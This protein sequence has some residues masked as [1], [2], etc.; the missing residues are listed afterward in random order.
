[1]TQELY[2]TV[3]SVDTR[4]LGEPTV[5]FAAAG[6]TTLYVDDA[7]SFN[8][9][10][11]QALVDGVLY[12]Y[13]EI[14]VEVNTLELLTVLEADVPEGALVEVVPA[15]PVKVASVDLGGEGDAVPVIVPH[16]LV[17][18]LVDGVRDEH[19]SETVLCDLKGAQLVIVDVVGQ[20]LTKGTID[21]DRLN[22]G[23]VADLV[24]DPQ[25]LSERWSPSEPWV[26]LGPDD[27]YPE[28]NYARCTNDGATID[29]DF[30]LTDMIPVQAG[31]SVRVA[32]LLRFNSAAVTGAGLP[33]ESR[34]RVRVEFY[35]ADGVTSLS[36]SEQLEE[37]LSS[38][39][40]PDVWTTLAASFP[41]PEG[42][43]F[44]RAKFQTSYQTG[45]AVDFIK[46]SVQ[47]P[48]NR[49]ASSSYVEGAS[50]WALDDNVS[51]VEDLNVLNELGAGG[52]TTGALTVGGVD[53]AT[54]INTMPRGIVAYD[55]STTG[56]DTGNNYSL[57]EFAMGPSE[58]GRLYRV[59]FIGHL[60]SA[61]IN[62]VYD[63]H[64]HMTTNNTTPTSA[65]PIIRS[66][67]V[68][69]GPGAAS[70]AFIV[71]KVFATGD[72][73]NVRFLLAM[74]RQ[75]GN[76]PGFVYNGGGRQLTAYVED[77][78]LYASAADA[79]TLSQKSFYT[80]PATPQ[81]PNPQPK[82]PQPDP[83]VTYTDVPFPCTWSR[84]YD[85]DGGVRQGDDTQNLY[86]GYYSGTHG[87]T[88]S[89]FGFDDAL[90]RS[91][92]AGAT[93]TGIKLRFRAKTTYNYSG[94]TYR[95]TTGNYSAKPGSWSG[96]NTNENRAN[97][98]R[99][100]GSTQTHN[101]PLAIANEF[102]SGTTK[103]LG[104][105]PAPSTSH[106]YYVTAYGNGSSSEPVLYLSYKR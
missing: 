30:Y 28:L 102:K 104:F 59:K 84:S 83:V 10:G 91:R 66:Q 101:L 90:I 60:Q 82:P 31:Q 8:S 25:M 36:G 51:Q 3:L 41:V 27:V 72:Y 93:M 39:T 7:A 98:S 75:Y 61:S 34:G 6:Q 105:G 16:A 65:S 42:Y 78:G 99:K 94:G 50:G 89:L 9:L 76:G 106:E 53:F 35:Q 22:L 52:I 1:M 56:D 33:S 13:A 86:Q 57:F 73:A 62:D 26:I 92:T 5:A 45:G 64:I 43:P 69:M 103:C 55:L 18:E 23:Q 14:D 74:D 44:A 20:P 97:F 87:N 54:L 48:W 58:A 2:G 49:V 37:L 11:G 85:S 46:P 17:E 81:E 71:E 19:T 38:A 80:P 68:N 40:T 29:T 96:A 79:G 88:R 4:N 63:L 32:G 95:L 21:P 47:V 100:A 12:S 70:S 77:C 15:S 67:R 24:Q